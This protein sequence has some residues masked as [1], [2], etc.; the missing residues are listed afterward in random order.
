MSQTLGFIDG[1][2]GSYVRGWAVADGERAAAITIRE[3][4]GKLLARGPAA[5]DRPD[6]ERLGYRRACGFRI[7]VRRIGHVG[8]LH[9]FADGIELA[10]SPVR[11]GA[12]LYDGALIISDG[13]ASGWIMERTDLFRGASVR[14]HDQDGVLLGEAEACIEADEADPLHAPARFSIELGLACFG[15]PDL[16]VRASVDGTRFAEARCAM[17]LDGYLDALTPRR[18]GG[19][20][21]SPDAPTRG[22]AIEVF[23]DGIQVGAGTC[24]FPREDVRDRY[25][26]A[27]RVGF[28][29]ALEAGVAESDAPPVYSVRLAGTDAELFDGPLAIEERTDAIEAARR[30]G[31]Q[32]QVD[33]TLSAT[34]RAV[35]R[36]ALAA[37][38]GQRRHGAERTRV[39]V[40]HARPDLPG[41]RRLCIVIPCYR[42]VAVTRACVDSVLAARDPSRDAIVLVDDCSPEPGMAALLE[43]FARQPGVFLLTSTE[44]QGFVRAA[45][46]GIGACR[47]G[48]ILLLNS[49]TR[50]F[51][52]V[53]EEL[54]RIAR[55]SPDIGTV[56]PLSNNATLFSYPHMS[57][58]NASLADMGWEDIAAV[59][60]EANGGVAIDVPTGHGFCL[61]IRRETL[62]L[63]GPFDEAFGRGYGEENDFCQR[64]ADL[65]FRNVAAA[66][67]FVEHRESVSFGDEKKA[68]LEANLARLARMYPEYIAAVAT[69]E[70]GDGL[71]RARWPIDAARL[72]KAGEN[73]AR[74]ALVVTNWL[75]GGA[76]KAL[77]DIE[78]ASGYGE[79]DKLMLSCRADGVIELNAET[80]ALRAVFAADEIV[81]LFDLLSVAPI[82]RVVVH[83]VL[84][85]PPGFLDRL[86]GLVGVRHAIFHV[87]DFYTLCP[88]VTMIDAAGQFCDIAPPPDLPAVPCR[89][90]RARGLS[91]GCPR[92]GGAPRPHGHAAGRLSS[93]RCAVGERGG[94]PA[95]GLAGSRGD[96]GAASRGGARHR[97]RAAPRDR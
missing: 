34:D 29:I 61:L 15:R 26:H 43:M 92:P 82:T 12:G 90:G 91:A 69:Y 84:G 75:G 89:R 2:E 77:A 13:V 6:V 8:A 17:R 76:R 49:D 35:L 65:G 57:L 4:G 11:V 74:F 88:R 81:A 85:F 71:R 33:L 25:P 22:V 79:A 47:D 58:P 44:N 96:S 30:L 66:G 97:I 48:D 83:Q 46:R 50:V 60:R 9:V 10:G 37:F 54:C 36:R 21:L 72:R 53:L 28:E 7:P 42:D 39:R 24:D 87:H 52:G 73:G 32:A 16:I 67:A 40:L 3:P 41:G 56:T 14:L 64:V 62:D 38:V 23:R 20:L 27:W 86:A 95:P 5:L 93:R 80:P 68:L 31:R 94:I 63:V 45:N 1:L 59:V 78:A 51:P 19:W 55:L 18:C 70:R